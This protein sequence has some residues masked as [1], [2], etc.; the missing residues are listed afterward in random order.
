MQ[1]SV[2]SRVEAKRRRDEARIKDGHRQLP[3]CNFCTGSVGAPAFADNAAKKPPPRK[4]VKNELCRL[5]RVILQVP[6]GYYE[7]EKSIGDLR[8]NTV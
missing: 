2:R 3:G 5:H 6:Y 1:G 7:Q 4:L 8:I